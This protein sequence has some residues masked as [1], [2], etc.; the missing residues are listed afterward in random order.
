[1]SAEPDVV[2]ADPNWW[3]AARQFWDHYSRTLGADRL[4]VV[5]LDVDAW[6]Q[7]HSLDSIT[8]WLQGFRTILA[9]EDPKRLFVT[10]TIILAWPE[11]P[12][13]SSFDNLDR[14]RHLVLAGA[15]LRLKREPYYQRGT[16]VQCASF[17]QD[18]KDAGLLLPSNSSPEPNKRSAPSFGSQEDE[19]DYTAREQFYADPPFKWDAAD[20][21]TLFGKKSPPP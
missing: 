5:G 4:Q 3:Q 19:D 7:R 12:K 15:N 17:Q 14:F 8:S 16:T 13:E 2:L 18:L 21:A 20:V 10:T 11:D 9:T 1:M 6:L